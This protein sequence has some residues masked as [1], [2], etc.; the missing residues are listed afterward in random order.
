MSLANVRDELLSQIPRN[1]I[2]DDTT[3]PWAGYSNVN[4]TVVAIAIEAIW[5]A[6]L[7][8]FMNEILFIPLGMKCTSLGVPTEKPIDNKGWVVDSH[9]RRHEL[10]RPQYRADGAEAAA[11]GVYSTAHD[12]DLFFKFIIDT[13]HHQQRIP[14][15]DLS[16]L[17]KVLKIT[18]ET[19]ES[20]R[21]TPLGLYTSLG[22]SVIG[23]L[24]TNRAQFSSESFSKYNVT[25]D[26]SENEIPIYYMAGSAVAC[27]CATALHVGVDR[28]FAVIVLTNTSGP[29]DA[30]DHI[31]RLVLQRMANWIGKGRSSSRL[32]KPISV[33]EMVKRNW[34][35]SLQKWQA[36]EQKRALD[37]GYTPIISKDIEGLF[38]GENFNQ[39]LVISK[40]ADGR[41]YITVDGPLVLPFPTELELF[42]IDDSSVKMNIPLHLSVD[43]LDGG[44]WS[45]T[46]FRVEDRDRVVVA[47]V[48]TTDV[49]E[50]KFLRI[51]SMS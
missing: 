7:E 17:A 38:K 2:E 15:F 24:S 10:Q 22:S 41:I 31:L 19:G 51:S 50:D 8:S 39:R 44:D 42:W 40:K 28:S 1:D 34:V 43:W 32:G 35:E 26:Q 23:A 27:S 48:R 21:F 46:V 25:A 36:V 14:G 45:N 29:V 4:Y 13:F 5:G 37:R 49:G 47:L 33:K 9:G 16:A 6:N 20:L 18:Y 11:L 12:L 30:A 3:K